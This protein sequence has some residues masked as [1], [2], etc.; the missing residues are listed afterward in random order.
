MTKRFPNLE[1]KMNIHIHEDERTPNRLNI[2]DLHFDTLSS[3]SQKSKT[4]KEI[5][6]NAAREK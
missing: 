1:R 2:R 6:L 4:K 3:N 5:M